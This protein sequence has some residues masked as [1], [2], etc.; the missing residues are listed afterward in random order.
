[1]TSR[2]FLLTIL[3]VCIILQVSFINAL[4]FPIDRIPLVLIVAIYLYQR[5]D[6]K[7]VWWWLP[8]Y[9]AFLDLLSISYVPLEWISYSVLTVFIIFSSQ[10]IFTNNSFYGM[11]ATAG[12]SC[13][14]LAVT[15]SI[16]SGISSM[17]YGTVFL[18]GTIV[19][20]HL[21]AAFL[22]CSILL[23]IFP[24]FRKIIHTVETYVF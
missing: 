6:K 16:I 9:G 24:W 21:W 20:I 14:I 13:V 7:G 3:F 12:I 1:M 22:G 4:P 10:Q 17:L 19:S 23:F 15:Q 8:I 5:R 18:G 2:I 11:A